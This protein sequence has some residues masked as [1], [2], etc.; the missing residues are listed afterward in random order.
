LELY[1][2][3]ENVRLEAAYRLGGFN[4]REAHDFLL[5]AL[6]KGKERAEEEAKRYARGK[7]AKRS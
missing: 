7:G 1:E 5:E 2:R 6:K 3:N 4:S